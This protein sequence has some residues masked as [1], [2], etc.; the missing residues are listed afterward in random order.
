MIR[1]IPVDAHNG[2]PVRC[3][4]STDKARLD[5]DMI[6]QFLSEVSYWA[7]G[8]T[9]ATV[10]NAI[11]NSLCFGVYVGGRQAGFARVVTDGATFAWLCDLF[12]LES[13]R[14]R[15]LGKQLVEQIVGHPEL[16]DLR[17]FLLATADAHGLYA[18]HGGFIPLQDVQKWMMRP[19][20][21]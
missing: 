9:R 1:E 15:G 18:E 14:G 6:H 16:R 17:L 20:R 13:H 4:I 5:L 2:Q 11:Q 12:I 10:E 7:M 3:E 8:R 21:P 19:R